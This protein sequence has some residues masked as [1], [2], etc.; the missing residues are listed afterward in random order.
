MILKTKKQ[1]SALGFFIK[2]FAKPENNLYSYD[3]VWL[4][5]SG[6][7]KKTYEFWESIK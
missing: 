6:P 4:K 5:L 1:W 3:N 2:S 7:T